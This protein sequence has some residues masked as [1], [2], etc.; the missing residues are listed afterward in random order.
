MVR[1]YLANE[2][3]EVNKVKKLHE[4]S[5]IFMKLTGTVRTQLP[6]STNG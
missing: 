5:I 1:T 2:V 6:R 4:V 3:R